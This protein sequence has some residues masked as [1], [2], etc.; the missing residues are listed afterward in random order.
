MMVSTMFM[1]IYVSMISGSVNS[2]RLEKPTSPLDAGSNK[3]QA[4]NL[5]LVSAKQLN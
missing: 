3:F 4:E 1:H 2:S 5:Y